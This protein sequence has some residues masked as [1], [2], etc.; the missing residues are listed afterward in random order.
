MWNQFFYLFYLFQIYLNN[1]TQIDPVLDKVKAQF[2]EIWG[3]VG[4]MIPQAKA[5]ESKKEE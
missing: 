1:K 4:A 3:K 2:D 5:V